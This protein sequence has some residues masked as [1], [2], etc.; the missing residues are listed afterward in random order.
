[1]VSLAFGFGEGFALVLMSHEAAC[2][3]QQASLEESWIAW[4]NA[5]G[6]D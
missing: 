1:M 6:L 3:S 5:P 2:A 4:K